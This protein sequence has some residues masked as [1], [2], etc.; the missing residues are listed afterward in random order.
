MNSLAGFN[1]LLFRDTEDIMCEVPEH[2]N[3]STRKKVSRNFCSDAAEDHTATEGSF[4]QFIDV[5]AR[6]QVLE[7]R[8]VPTRK[9]QIAMIDEMM[10]MRCL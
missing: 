6:E 10:R 9:K 7:Y 5:D 4:W 1:I 8:A 2:Q 3:T